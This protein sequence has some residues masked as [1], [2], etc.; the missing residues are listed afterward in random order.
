MKPSQELE[1]LLKY[2][3]L[4]KKGR[5]DGDYRRFLKFTG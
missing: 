2:F 4:F 1:A 3:H 5:T